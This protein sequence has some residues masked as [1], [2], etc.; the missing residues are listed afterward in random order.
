MA[1]LDSIIKAASNLKNEND[2][3]EEPLNDW[4][5]SESAMC[6]RN[7][8]RAV[9]LLLVNN[10]Y[11]PIYAHGNLVNLSSLASFFY[12][13]LFKTLRSFLTIY[14]SSNPTWIK[15]SSAKNDFFNPPPDDDTE[16]KIKFMK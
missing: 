4:L 12:L 11:C 3:N 14:V 7:L 15:M 10:D 1:D 5:Q 9:H 16:C 8:D 6:F 13:A 2:S